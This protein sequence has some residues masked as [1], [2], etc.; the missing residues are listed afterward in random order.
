MKLYLYVFEYVEVPFAGK[1]VLGTS[2]LTRLEMCNHRES[3][4]KEFC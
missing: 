1:E 4:W 3:L 2:T